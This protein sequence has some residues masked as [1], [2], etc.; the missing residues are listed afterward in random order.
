MGQLSS[1]LKSSQ[2][3]V[4][5]EKIDTKFNRKLKNKLQK[6]SNF[7]RHSILN[8]FKNSTTGGNLK[9]FSKFN[10]SDSSINHINSSTTSLNISKTNNDR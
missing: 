2:N 6:E 1:S 10:K 5:S 8:L 3:S 9:I 7:R 4:Q